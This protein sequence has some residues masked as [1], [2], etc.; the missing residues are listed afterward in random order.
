MAKK[1]TTKAVEKR[2]VGRPTKLD[3]SLKIVA[4]NLYQKGKTD[5]EVAEIC[6][7]ANSTIY[8]WKNKDPEFSEA[9]KKAKAHADE[10]VVNALL[11]KC[12]GYEHPE[13]IVK[14]VSHGKDMGS[15]I[16]EVEVTKRYPP[17]TEAIK[18]WLKNRQP[19]KWR[20][21]QELEVSN[22]NLAEGIEKARDRSKES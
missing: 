18:F 13:T 9:I 14:T 20:D 17:D 1:K 6:G 11:E 19:E 7:V 12:L 10:A 3:K 16:E 22:G 5:A 2:K 21:K 4:L 8:E 15:S